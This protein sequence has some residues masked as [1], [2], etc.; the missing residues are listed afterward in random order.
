MKKLP[1][2]FIILLSTTFSLGHEKNFLDMTIGQFK[3]LYNNHNYDS[4]FTLFTPHSQKIVPLA[5]VK[6]NMETLHTEF[7]AMDSFVYMREQSDK[8]Y[9]KAY[10]EKKTV[11][12]VAL[13][14]SY[15]LETFY[16]VPDSGKLAE[17][18]PEHT[19]QLRQEEVTLKTATGNLYGTLT[20]PDFLTKVPLIIIIP[21]QGPIDRNG[22]STSIGLKTNAYQ[23]VAE[24]LSIVGIACLRYD[25]RG[26]GASEKSFKGEAATTFNTY[27]DDAIAFINM[28]NKDG[29]FSEVIVLGHTEGALV[30]MVAA[31]KAKVSKFISLAAS[32]AAPDKIL[33]FQFASKPQVLADRAK[34]IIDSL[35]KGYTVKNVND[36]ELLPFFR[37]SV[38]PFMRTWL[39]YDP[40][41]EIK[42]LK[43]PVMLLQGER[44]LQIG[45]SEVNI[46]NKAVPDARLMVFRDMNHVLK[47]ATL[48]KEENMSTYS[49]PELPLNKGLIPT[50]YNFVKGQK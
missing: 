19:G 13:M 41:I 5:Q 24:S 21:D 26:V 22:N 43:I 15:K 38:Q 11:T 50:L 49:K 34:N 28:M 16:F 47:D 44:D 36:P 48:D 32:C 27:V 4:L 37:P 25:K 35:K 33:E 12:L 17:K 45:V 46:L 10:F 2:L 40:M 3:E 30:G 39:K 7:G 42:K 8:S 14:Q 1:L 29:R 18:R 31:Q 20:R 6:S 9:Y 23:M